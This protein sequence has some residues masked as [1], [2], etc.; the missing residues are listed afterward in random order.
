[1]FNRMRLFVVL[2]I[3]IFASSA[4]VLVGAQDATPEATVMPTFTRFNLNTATGDDFLTIPDMNDR[5]VREYMEYRP[6]VS[7]LQ[8]RQEIGKYVGDTQVAAWE[9]YVFVPIQIDQA[10]VETLKQIPGVDDTIANELIAARPYTT[11]DA[12]LA[13][14]ATYLTADQMTFAPNYLEGYIPTE[15]T[16]EATADAT[17]EAFTRFNLNIG[18]SDDFLTIPDMNNRMVREYMEYRPYVSILQFRQEIGK[19]VGDA[20]VAAWEP[21]I[22]VPIQIDQADVETLKQIPGVD[23]TIANELIA[24]RPYTTNE[25]FL[26]KLTT[27]LTPEQ[28]AFA[29]NFLDG[30]TLAATTATP[31][32]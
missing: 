17:V 5:M 1:M 3:A 13:K 11:N 25:A 16:P 24:A 20:Q 6:Y 19:Y 10:D 7:I 22:F 12:F 28:V 2:L 21:Y 32:A 23:D 29:Q 31:S 4:L 9:P 8:F 30:Y 18:T 26:A 15:A 14:L 27:Y